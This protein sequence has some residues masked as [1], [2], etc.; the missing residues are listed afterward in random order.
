M[1]WQPIDTAPKDG[2]WI[3]LQGGKTIGEDFYGYYPKPDDMKRPV[4]AK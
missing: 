2:T 1:T 4:V 3:L